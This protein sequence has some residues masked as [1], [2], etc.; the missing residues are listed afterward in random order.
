MLG[1]K[2]ILEEINVIL[3]DYTQEPDAFETQTERE[4]NKQTEKE[5][6]DLYKKQEKDKYKYFYKVKAI[7]NN[8]GLPYE[9]NELYLTVKVYF[10]NKIDYDTFM[11]KEKKSIQ[12]CL[13]QRLDSRKTFD[14]LNADT[15]GRRY[16]ILHIKEGK[17]YGHKTDK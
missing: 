4:L 7:L 6:N 10:N 9:E 3:E 13:K 17:V 11:A 8:L 2:Q 5:I 16:E 1:L 12:R 15:M 14:K